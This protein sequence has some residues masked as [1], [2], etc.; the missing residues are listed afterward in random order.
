MDR[1]YRVIASNAIPTERLQEFFTSE[2]ESWWIAQSPEPIVDI[3]DHPLH[4]GYLTVAHLGLSD[5]DRDLDALQLQTGHLLG[6]LP[7]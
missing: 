4:G 5:G 3:E 1:R 6:A 2:L 7:V